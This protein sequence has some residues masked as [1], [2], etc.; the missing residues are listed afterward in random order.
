MT[1]IPKTHETAPV[2]PDNIHQRLSAE[3]IQTVDLA[4]NDVMMLVGA[5]L[6]SQAVLFE[7][8]PGVGK[9]KTART[10]AISMGGTFSRTQGTPDVRPLDVIG[11]RVLTPQR[12][13]EFQPGPIFN[14]VF[15]YDELP[16]SSPK[17]QSALLE[18]MEE[19]QVTVA[20]TTY[21]LPKPFFVIATQNP[22]EIGQGVNPLT[23]AN[24]DRFAISIELPEQSAEVM[25]RVANLKALNYQPKTVATSE[26]LRLAQQMIAEIVIP[27]ELM[28][29]AAKLVVA[30]R[31]HKSV[32]AAES[33][34]LTSVWAATQLV[35]S[36]FR[37]THKYA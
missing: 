7:G 24:S 13:W 32:E 10:L 15:L 14:N 18:A 8:D 28:M 31:K 26:E 22:R 12:Q 9:T 6:T 35:R 5:A 37:F 30:V 33:V 21:P 3:L 4:T 36:R 23:K 27:G 29:D 34:L 16:R 19:K 2:V 20:N 25:V 17:T 1:S 11:S